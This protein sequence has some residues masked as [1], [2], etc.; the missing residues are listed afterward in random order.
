MKDK[1]EAEMF[2]QW[3]QGQ[4]KFERCKGRILGLEACLQ[5]IDQNRFFRGIR[6]RALIKKHKK[7]LEMLK[8]DMQEFKDMFKIDV[9]GNK[10]YFTRTDNE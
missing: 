3:L 4:S 6:I 7:E 1:K 5:I 10:L 2:L 9:N 8:E